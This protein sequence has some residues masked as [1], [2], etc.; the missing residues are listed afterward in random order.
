M[1]RPSGKDVGRLLM[2]LIMS[3]AMAGRF[4]WFPTSSSSS[5]DGD[6]SS[7]EYVGVP[8]LGAITSDREVRTIIDDEKEEEEDARGV[9]VS[10]QI[11]VESLCID[12]KHYMEEQL[13][14][15]YQALGTSIMTLS[16][17]SFG[18]AKFTSDD[19]DDNVDAT[20]A[21]NNTNQL[22]CQHG[23][24][25]CDVNSY[26]QCAAHVYDDDVTRYLPFFACLFERLP[27]GHRDDLF[28][29]ADIAA[30]TGSLHWPSLQKCHDDPTLA[31]KLQK[32]A[33]AATPAEHTYVP[34]VVIDGKHVDE[35]KTSLVE[36]VCAAYKGRSTSSTSL[37]PDAT[38]PGVPVRLPN[39]RLSTS[40]DATP[41]T[42]VSA[43][44]R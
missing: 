28:P 42:P 22:T 1:M 35:T 7:V 23:A 37:C 39:A 17:I 36:M 26:Q 34:W 33:A 6:D 13:L 12:S 30:C 40:H 4:W 41:Q 31:W 25:E 20:T 2:V 29:P 16:I 5:F 44:T 11:Y 10:V 38:Q 21:Y 32:R 14:P 27:M 15:A 24:A 19:D 18:N 43:M 8:L 3:V 9:K